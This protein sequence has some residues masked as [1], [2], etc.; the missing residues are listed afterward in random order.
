MN[1]LYYKSSS[2]VSPTSLLILFLIT[3]LLGST[4]SVPYLFLVQKIP[5]VY[6]NILLPLLLGL[7]LGFVTTYIAKDLKVT[8]KYLGLAACGIGFIGFNIVKWAIYIYNTFEY[9][10]YPFLQTI[11]EIILSPQIFW[12]SICYINENNFWGL[13]SDMPL[14]GPLLW[15]VWIGE[16]GLIALPLFSMLS[17]RLEMPFIEQDNEWAEKCT[18]VAVFS[19]F[20]VKSSKS[21]IEAEPTILLKEP[22]LPCP[23]IGESYVLGEIFQSKDGN[24]NY[25]LLTEYNVNSK[26]Q[27]TRYKRLKYLHV[28]KNFVN[29]LLYNA[30]Y[31]ETI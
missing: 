18:N 25:L 9:T 8:N 14:S 6:V 13:I 3:F 7:L 15:L 17:A 11:K 26:G 10:D 19:S 4:L 16:I 22:L 21:T 1:H 29:A 12:K 30:S 20:D 24:E 5:L 23:P 2:H 31:T 28:S 27:Y